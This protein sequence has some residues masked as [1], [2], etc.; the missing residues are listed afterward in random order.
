M[1]AGLQYLINNNNEFFTSFCSSLTTIFLES[2]GEMFFFSG[3]IF[4]TYKVFDQDVYKMK[5][6]GI[7]VM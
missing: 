6:V 7:S 1:F 2:N 4:G 5:L 3:F